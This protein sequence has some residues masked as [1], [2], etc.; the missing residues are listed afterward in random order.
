MVGV[1][2][3]QDGTKIETN[4][5]RDCSNYGGVKY[6][7]VDEPWM[8]D[9]DEC[10]VMNNTRCCSNNPKCLNLGGLIDICSARSNIDQKDD[11]IETKAK[12]GIHKAIKTDEVP[13]IICGQG[14][15]LS[16]YSL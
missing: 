1:M 16:I 14:L 11:S 10:G 9:S 4:S 12:I 8:C 2:V 5:T 13:S 3:C 7:S 15:Q 6:C